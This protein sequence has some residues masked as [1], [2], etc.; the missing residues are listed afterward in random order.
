MTPEELKHIETIVKR[1]LKKWAPRDCYTLEQA[2]HRL[3]IDRHRIKPDYVFTGRIGFVMMD[4]QL[5]IPNYEIENFLK[6]NTKY[7]NPLSIKKGA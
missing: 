7:C 6:S 2:A 3:G 1:T 4:G 5:K